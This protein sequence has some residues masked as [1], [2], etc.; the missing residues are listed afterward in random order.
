MLTGTIVFAAFAALIAVPLAG[1]LLLRYLLTGETSQEGVEAPVPLY[2]MMWRYFLRTV[3]EGP[4]LLT[5][6]RNER[7]QFKAVRR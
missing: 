3:G 2:A 7:G 6:R 4:R 1:L 5:Y